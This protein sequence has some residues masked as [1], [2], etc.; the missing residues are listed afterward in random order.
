MGRLHSRGQGLSLAILSLAVVSLAIVAGCGG[1]TKPSTPLFPGKVN[2]SPSVNTSIALGGTINFLASV[3]TASGTNLNTPISFSSSDTSIL[4]LASN[5]VACA[6]HWDALF[7]TCTPGNVG[8]VQVTASALGGTS[9]PTYVFVHPAVDSVTVSGVL[10]GP[11]VQEPCLSQTQ[12]M[13]LEAHAFSQGNDVTASVGPFTWSANNASVVNLVPINDTAYNFPTNRASAIA[14]TPGITQIFATATGVSSTTFQQPQYTSSSNQLSPILDFFSTCPIQSINLEVGS[15]G[16]GQTSFVISKGT[17][18]TVV[19]TVTDIMGVSSLP[20]TTGGP[21]LSKI[22]LTWTSSR[23]GVMAIPSG[24]QL[25]CSATTSPGSVNVTASCTPPG[26][27]VGFPVIPDSLATATQIQACTTFFHAQFSNFQSCQQLI[28]VAVY[29]STAIS[30]T[31]TGDPVDG[32]VF[33]TSTGCAHM[34]PQSCVTSGYYLSTTTAVAG[35]ENPLPTTPNSFMFDPG[36]TKVFMGSEFGAQTINPANFGTANS[37]FASLGTV[38]GTTLAVSN[39]GLLAVYTDTLHTPNQV[40]V[41]NTTNSTTPTATALN[42][43]AADVAA[44]SPDGLKTYIMGGTTGTSLY[45]YST[46][47]SLQGPITLAGAAHAAGFSPNSAFGF[48]AEGG[49]SPNVTAFATCNNQVAATLPLPASPILMQVL[50]NV[51]IDGRDSYG[52]PIPD[53][54]HIVALDS[55]G[56][57][58]VTATTSAPV[59]GTLCPQVLTFT[60]NDPLRQ[61]QRVELGQGTIQPINFFASPDGTQLYVVNASSSTILAYNFV[62]GAVV[63]GIELVNNANPLSADAT[64]DTGIIMVAGNDGL[65]HQVSTSLTGADLFQIPFPNLPN[66]LNPFCTNYSS[67]GVCALNAV[68]VRP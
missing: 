13:T 43:T 65:L 2:I 20:N 30:G 3:Q 51:H 6:G 44:F 22:P 47:Q 61:A 9:I 25:S 53:G 45:I 67:T 11:P 35:N 46:L 7:T 48:I 29:A 18:Q 37:P 55:T 28:P 33:A 14:L 36:G 27:N 34:P 50:P 5:G 60:S 24:C 31:A 58:I 10:D 64:V 39:N 38:T 57:D 4:N 17:S 1:K 12:S 26:C 8:V 19:A 68:V 15:V 49:T 21:V 40:Y 63:G 23:P 59:S 41:V 62:A 32:N 42:I 16:S 66:Y 52:Y 56:F 54:I